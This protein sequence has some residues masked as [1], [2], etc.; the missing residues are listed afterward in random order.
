MYIIHIPYTY[1]DTHVCTDTYVRYILYI[2]LQCIC[3][4]SVTLD[5]NIV[6]LLL[7]LSSSL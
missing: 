1:T 5:V 7:F 3:I 2:Y 6:S 4:V